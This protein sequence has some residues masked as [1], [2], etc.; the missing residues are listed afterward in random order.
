MT[1]EEVFRD[2]DPNVPVIYEDYSEDIDGYLMKPIK[3]K[4][5]ISVRK[6]EDGIVIDLK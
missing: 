6:T 2:I 5:V 1:L 3:M 4:T